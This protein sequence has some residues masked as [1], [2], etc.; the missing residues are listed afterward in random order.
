MD[1]HIFAHAAQEKFKLK[2]YEILASK[3]IKAYVKVNIVD[4]NETTPKNIKK[5]KILLKE[6][7]EKKTD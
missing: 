6:R 7:N 5:R 2:Y 3:Y 1:G 4:Y